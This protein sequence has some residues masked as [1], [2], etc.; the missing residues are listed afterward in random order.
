M[1]LSNDLTIQLT[2]THCFHHGQMF[3]IVMGLEQGVTSKELDQDASDTPNVT[4]KTPSKVENDLRRT[5]MA[6]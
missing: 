2:T 6:S 4:G 5:V 1:D 3:Q